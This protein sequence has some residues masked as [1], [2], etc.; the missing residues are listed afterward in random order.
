M[1]PFTSL[2]MKMERLGMKI[3]R[4]KMEIEYLEWMLDNEEFD[5]DTIQCIFIN[6]KK[7]DI[8]KIIEKIE[9]NETANEDDQVDDMANDSNDNSSD[10]SSDVSTKDLSDEGKK[11]RLFE[12]IDDIDETEMKIHNICS[13]QSPDIAEILMTRMIRSL[14]RYRKLYEDIYGHK[15]DDKTLIVCKRSES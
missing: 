9:I 11:K 12:M 13:S 8:N 7:L 1:T 14:K 15:K 6:L 2:K 3:E 5:C 4:L 10:A